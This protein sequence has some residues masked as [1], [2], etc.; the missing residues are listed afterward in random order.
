M[1]NKGYPPSAAPA[2]PRLVK[3]DQGISNDEVKSLLLVPS[4]FVIRYSIFC[5]S[6]LIF[7]AAFE[8]ACA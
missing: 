4:A 3:G 7:N 5:G 8:K 1:S 2:S 6:L